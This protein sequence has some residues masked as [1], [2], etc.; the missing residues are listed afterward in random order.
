[1]IVQSIIPSMQLQNFAK[2]AFIAKNNGAPKIN[3][4]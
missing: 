2:L 1:M 3:L 4:T